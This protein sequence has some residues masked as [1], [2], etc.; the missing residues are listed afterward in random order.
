MFWPQFSITLKLKINSWPFLPSLLQCDTTKGIWWH[1]FCPNSSPLGCWEA[2]G[3]GVCHPCSLWVGLHLSNSVALW[4]LNER[5]GKRLCKEQRALLTYGSFTL[6][7]E[8]IVHLWTLS[9]S[10]ELQGNQLRSY[11]AVTVV[12]R[13]RCLWTEQKLSRHCLKKKLWIYGLRL[14]IYLYWISNKR[15]F[16][17]VI[18][19]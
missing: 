7:R 5:H 4:L 9:L 6:Q 19:P 15:T 2:A 17:I 13:H 3:C 10:L 14:Y 1:P 8:V 12:Q 18:F 16:K 11:W